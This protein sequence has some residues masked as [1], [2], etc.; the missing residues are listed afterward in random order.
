[1]VWVDYLVFPYFI[2]RYF[3]MFGL[4]NIIVIAVL[5]VTAITGVFSQGWWL[6]IIVLCNSWDLV[7][8][9]RIIFVHSWGLNVAHSWD[10]VIFSGFFFSHS[11]ER[12]HG[13][14]S[15]AI[16]CNIGVI[17]SVCVVWRRVGM[18]RLGA[19]FG[20]S[21]ILGALSMS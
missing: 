14:I 8:L 11:C 5:V 17:V 13:T 7:V 6:I 20:S 3:I 18:G 4:R 1:V 19:V 12:I 10:L 21:R 16:L 9:L 2:L 15:V